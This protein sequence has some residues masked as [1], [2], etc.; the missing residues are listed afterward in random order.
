MLEFLISYSCRL[1]SCITV[2]TLCCLLQIV[3]E[4]DWEMDD[5]E[6]CVE[7]CFEAQ[8]ARVAT[9]ESASGLIFVLQCRILQIR[10]FKKVAC[11]RVRKKNS[12]Y[13]IYFVLNLWLS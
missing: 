13:C 11:Q 8:Y 10:K 5:Y 9:H 7:M 12:R 4:F 2:F 6:V 3:D 1:L